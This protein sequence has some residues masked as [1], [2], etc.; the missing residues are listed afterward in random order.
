MKRKYIIAVLVA[1]ALVA[2]W[3]VLRPTHKPSSPDVQTNQSSAVA[4][5]TCSMHP[6]IHQP[7]PGQC[8]ICG[9]DLIPVSIGEDSASAEGVP[10]LSLSPAAI[11]IA[12]V[13]TAPVERK[14]VTSELHLAGKVE[15]DETTIR[16]VAMLTDGVI[17]RLYVNYVGVPVRK[18][19]HMAEFYS[20]EVYTAAKELLIARGAPGS[21]PNP[22][23]LE[24]ARRKLE[25]F[26][27]T[28]QQI[29]DMLAKN[30]FSKTFTV[31]SPADGVLV[32]MGGHEGS[33]LNRGQPLGSVADLQH[34]WVVLDAYESDMPFIR[35]GQHVSF[36]VEAL[37][38]RTFTGFVSFIPPAVDDMT[39]TMKIRLNVPNA[40]MALRPAMFVRATVT[41]QV[42]A[43]GSIVHPEMAG[44]W[45]SP[46]HPEIVKDQPGTCDICG[47][48]L[49]SAESLGLVH[50]AADE[51]PLV[52][53]AS[54]PLITGRRA[55]VYVQTEPG[56]YEGREVTLGP[57]AGDNYVVLSGLSPDEQVVVQGAF[58]IDSAMQIQA[59]PSMMSAAP[60]TA[61]H[62]MAPMTSTTPGHDHH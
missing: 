37:P 8:P 48:P 5:W 21:S 29:D 20:P 15:Y 57:R 2:A 16:E 50:G 38:G 34:V 51:P 45:V 36:T 9:M 40:D 22:T 42:T 26:G 6:Q 46:M 30:N 12:S 39:R 17:D 32:S 18:G 61:V 23:L 59:K 11:S 13:L 44:K 28:D 52:I 62:T 33:W 35:Y 53:P 3:F 14:F 19:D 4:F 55:V 56:R 54:A 27:V 47:M 43:D 10:S 58:K 31:Y 25:L 24:G 60:E 1:V 7:Q 49:V 41:A